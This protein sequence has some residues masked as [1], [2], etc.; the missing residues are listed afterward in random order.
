MGSAAIESRSFESRSVSVG[1]GF[2]SGFEVEI[3]MEVAVEGSAGLAL[4]GFLAS[5]LTSFS[6][7]S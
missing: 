3:E 5:F 7:S 4:S 1:F 2:G 6:A